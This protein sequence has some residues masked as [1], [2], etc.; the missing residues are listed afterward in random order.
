MSLADK[1]LG[2]AASSAI[3]EPFANTPKG[4]EWGDMGPNECLPIRDSFSNERAYF[5]GLPQHRAVLALLSGEAL[6][7][8]TLPAVPKT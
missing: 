8:S 6:S 7:F 3:D 2:L 1:P 5:F 4:Q